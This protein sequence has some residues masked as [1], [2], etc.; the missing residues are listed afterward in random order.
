MKMI[1]SGHLLLQDAWQDLTERYVNL[2]Y[3]DGRPKLP[4]GEETSSFLLGMHQFHASYVIQQCLLDGEMVGLY[5]DLEGTKNIPAGFWR[6]NAGNDAIWNGI[7]PASLTSSSEWIFVTSNQ[8][9][10][11]LSALRMIEVAGAGLQIDRAEAHGDDTAKRKTL[12]AADIR[13]AVAML[14]KETRAKRMTRDAQKRLLRQSFAG[15]DITEANFR[16][17]FKEV[18]T[19]IGAPRKA[20]KEG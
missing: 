1:P 2:A 15:K 11:L 7:T 18:P 10:D 13:S 14:S 17:I 8:Y 16:S 3:P 6:D 19:K 20:D 9:K 4:S 12:T 5:T